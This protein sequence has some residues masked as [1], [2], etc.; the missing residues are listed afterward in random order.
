MT[1][2][3]GVRSMQ[4]VLVETMGVRVFATSLFMVFGAAALL[5]AAVGVFSVLA[6]LVEQRTRE[7]GIRLALGSSRTAVRS[8]VAREASV[9][10]GVGLVI[11][12]A[13]AL[14]SG[15]VIEGMLF[16]VAVGDPM[17][18]GVVSLVAA[19]GAAAAAWLPARRATRIDPMIAMRDD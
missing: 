16:G 15:S 6:Y 8:L 11:G 12:G 13:I 2:V 19:A 9:L 17:V 3:Y 14:L 10:A 1:P 18:L 4:D 7:I 5:L